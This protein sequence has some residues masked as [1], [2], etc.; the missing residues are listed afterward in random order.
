MKTE[1]EGDVE[2]RSYPILRK[3]SVKLSDCRVW[4]EGRDFLSLGNS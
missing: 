2:I 3:L 1:P 4:L